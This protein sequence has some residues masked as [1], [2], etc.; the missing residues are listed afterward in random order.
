MTSGPVDVVIDELTLLGFGPG[1]RERIRGALERELSRLFTE[2]GA[3]G[4]LEREGSR[5]V[6]TAPA[7]GARVSQALDD[8]GVQV[9]RAVYRRLSR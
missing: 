6:R 2:F 9:A 5:A 8:V 3:P 7:L 4:G 1:D